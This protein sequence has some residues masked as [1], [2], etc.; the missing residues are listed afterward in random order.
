MKPTQYSHYHLTKNTKNG[1]LRELLITKQE[2]KWTIIDDWGDLT[3][4][5]GKKMWSSKTL[6]E[7]CKKAKKTIDQKFPKGTWLSGAAFPKYWN[8]Q[9][10]QK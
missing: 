10:E 9:H 1:G 7:A 4:T 6:K 2:H 5:M 8:K 3:G